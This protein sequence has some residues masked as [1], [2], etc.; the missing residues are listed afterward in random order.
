LDEKPVSVDSALTSTGL[1]LYLIQTKTKT[2]LF[3]LNETGDTKID[4]LPP[5]NVSF[6]TINSKETQ[7]QS[8]FGIDLESGLIVHILRRQE[9]TLLSVVYSL[10]GQELKRSTLEAPE[11]TV[12]NAIYHQ[13]QLY[14]LA[15]DQ[16][17]WMYLSGNNWLSLDLSKYPLETQIKIVPQNIDAPKFYISSK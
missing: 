4:L 16:Q 12:Q 11:L 6:E 5:Q 2:Y 10:Q 1:P 3:L 7:L 15:T 17:S 8:Q 9:E 13:S 14:L